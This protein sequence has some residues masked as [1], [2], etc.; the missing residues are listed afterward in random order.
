M[1]RMIVFAV[2]AFGLLLFGCV[3]SAPGSQVKNGTVTPGGNI[4]SGG[5]TVSTNMTAMQNGQ[6]VPIIPA[7]TSG[8]EYNARIT[9][10]GGTGPY[11]CIPAKGGLPGEL[12]FQEPGCTISGTAPTLPAGTQ[13]AVYQLTFTVSDSA[14]KSVGPMTF[15][16]AVNS[17]PI[18]FTPVQPPDGAVGGAYSYSFC[19]PQTN[20]S[21]CGSLNG[22]TDPSGGQ[23]PYHFSLDSGTGFPPA[24]LTLAQNGVLSG[25]PSAVGIRKFGVCAIDQA[26]SQKCGTVT[27]TVNPA[28]QV[29]PPK[30]AC[31]L[32]AY[33]NTTWSGTFHSIGE[34]GHTLT[35]GSFTFT[36]GA[37]DQYCG[38]VSVVSGTLTGSGLSSMSVN[39]AQTSDSINTLY[40]D[41][42]PE[43][44]S[45]THFMVYF[46]SGSTWVQL[47]LNPKSGGHASISAT[48][49]DGGDYSAYVYVSGSQSMTSQGERGWTAHKTG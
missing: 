4:S 3:A 11:H 18:I 41:D 1:N 35:T 16:L 13:S 8:E 21:M 28:Q 44:T 25:T 15:N 48:G 20:G 6:A 24:G 46:G 31:G 47:E 22:S 42:S 43:C 27:M 14:G 36:F 5:L 12:V 32:D 26:G 39:T 2:L 29:A 9:V 33:A 17:P 30:A 7:A 34:D 38:G 19:Q 10:T 45:I 37:T 40:C 23:P 49:M